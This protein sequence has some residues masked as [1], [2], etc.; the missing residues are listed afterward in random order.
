MHTNSAHNSYGSIDSDE[1]LIRILDE[2]KA[3]QT[4]KTTETPKEKGQ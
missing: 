3:I 2:E 4:T 1:R